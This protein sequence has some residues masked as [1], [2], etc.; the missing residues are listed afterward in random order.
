MTTNHKH[1]IACAFALTTLLLSSAAGAQSRHFSNW[2]FGTNCHFSWDASNKLTMSKPPASFNTGE[3]CA[4]YSDPLTGKLMLYTD[5]MSAWNA[6]GTKISTS[7][8]GGHSS[9]QYS[10]IIIPAPGYKGH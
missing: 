6:K 7:H 2:I 3:G 10:G 9:G 5:G 1:T 4:T 8:L